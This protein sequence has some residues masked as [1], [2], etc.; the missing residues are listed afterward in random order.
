M[1]AEKKMFGVTKNK[2]NVDLFCLTS[3]G[4]LRVELISYGAAIKSVLFPDEITY[5]F[6]SL[7]EY[8]AR[9]F[10][11]GAVIGRYAN[12]IAR[13]RFF[14]EG[15]EYCLERNNG[16]NHLHGGVRGFDR[17]VW[18]GKLLQEAGDKASAAFSIES[19]S[20]EE[21]YPGNVSARVM[22][23]LT[24]SNELHIVYSALSDSATPFNP[25]NHAFWNL[26]GAASGD[27]SAHELRLCCPFYLPV[28]DELIPT[29][30]ILSVKNTPM[31]FLSAKAIGRDI[32]K[33]K[34]AGY[35]HCFVIDGVPG[36]LN[37][38]AVVREPTTMRRM[39]VWTTMPGIQVYSGNNIKNARISCGAESKWRGAL[40]LETQ[41][42]PDSVNKN[43]FPSPFL[44]PGKE[45][46]FRTVHKFFVD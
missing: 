22:Y 16:N 10:F 30:E 1:K 14:L 28:D 44:L 4:G 21:G 11:F 13:G 35:D 9:R 17:R 40:C 37:L 6:D 36:E 24:D 19:P 2:E 5:G 12:R 20:G 32:D 45:C 43:H 3:A 31:D 7:E 26:A 25:T 38:A 42:F 18:K 15:R 33:V 27:I 39:E 23:T 46:I 29:G 8:E 41:L 34:P